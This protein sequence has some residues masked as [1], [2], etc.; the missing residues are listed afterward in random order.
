MHWFFIRWLPNNTVLF[1]NLSWCLS[2]LVISENP[3]S[4]VFQ[5]GR[6]AFHWRRVN[7]ATTGRACW[8]SGCRRLAWARTCMELCDHGQAE[9][10]GSCFLGSLCYQ[11]S[12]GPREIWMRRLSRVGAFG[13]QQAVSRTVAGAS[14]P[15]IQSTLRKPRH[16]VN[17][18]LRASPGSLPAWTLS[19]AHAR[20]CVQIAEPQSEHAFPSVASDSGFWR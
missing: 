4:F 10:S 1:W 13:T 6:G 18:G 16:Q 17:E 8:D 3:Q 20:V 7:P 14:E 2:L 5:P 19:P 12:C 9:P 15:F 11:S